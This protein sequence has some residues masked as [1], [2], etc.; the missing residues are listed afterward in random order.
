M[1]VKSTRFVIA[2]VAASAISLPATATARFQNDP[3]APPETP[4]AG[5]APT[6]TGDGFDWGDA[7]LGAGG[8]LTIVLLA[9][10]GVAIVRHGR[11]S[12]SPSVPAH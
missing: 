7:A 3:P 8:I 1:P 9:G 2:A 11:Q 12:D 5:V 6:S 10:G 4:Q